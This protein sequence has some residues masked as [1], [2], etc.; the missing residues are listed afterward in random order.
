MDKKLFSLSPCSPGIKISKSPKRVGFY[1]NEKK[2]WAK[3]AN[4]QQNDFKSNPI[5]QPII[6]IPGII[7]FMS[8]L[9][10][11]H[12]QIVDEKM[13]CGKEHHCL[14]CR[15][16]APTCSERSWWRKFWTILARFSNMCK[17]TSLP[18]MQRACPMQLNYEFQKI[19]KIL[20]NYIN[21]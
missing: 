10:Q 13:I 15:E 8:E 6:F 18:T 2:I 12:Q 17:R 14:P 21:Y 4:V 1:G 9:M 19:P 5:L 16:R 20:K 3:L 11:S 7:G